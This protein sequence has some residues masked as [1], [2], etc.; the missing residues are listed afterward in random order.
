MRRPPRS[1][2]VLTVGIGVG[3]GASAC[4]NGGGA[5]PQ[6][7]EDAS[8]G[9]DDGTLDVDDAYDAFFDAPDSGRD[10]A[11]VIDV[12]NPPECPKDDPGFGAKQKPCSVAASV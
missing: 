4:S 12:K 3:I 9:G 6:T 1:P 11:D 2:F 8:T 10:V 7:I 5:S